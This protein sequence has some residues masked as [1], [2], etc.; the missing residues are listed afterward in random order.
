MTMT[1]DIKQLPSEVITLIYSFGYPEYKEHMNEICHEIINY[2]GTGLVQYNLNLLREDYY[3]VHN[4][5]VNNYY[6][7]C[8][9][10]YLIHAV[11]NEVLEDL[12]I[13]CTRCY[14]CSKHCHNR[15]KNYYTDEV[16]IGENFETSEQCHCNCRQIA[17]S[18]KRS[19]CEYKR[20]K[21]YANVITFNTQFIP[22]HIKLYSR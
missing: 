8:M 7:T 4:Y 11:N 10:D 20:K 9:V 13:Q 3:N 21:K 12:F 6:V 16:S 19:H 17:R 15:P 1:F 18:I 2:T 5:Y 14:C 22:Q